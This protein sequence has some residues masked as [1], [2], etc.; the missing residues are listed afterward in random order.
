MKDT[1]HLYSDEKIIKEVRR[2]KLVFY[3]RTSS[4]FV[5]GIIPLIFISPLDI[6]LDSISD[7]KGGAVFGASFFLWIVVLSIIFFFRWT[8]YYLDVW[9]ITNKR[10]FDIEQR[11]MFNRSISVFL[12]SRI[13]DVT[14]ETEGLIATL[15]KFGTVHVHTA[16]EHHAGSPADSGE[17]VIEDA[18]NPI[19]I[20]NIIMD[21]HM[22]SLGH[23]T[24]HPQRQ[25]G[26]KGGV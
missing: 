8:D 12:L 10:I 18:D 11:G 4:L 15:F 7:G 14:V 19:M 6:L 23:N 16:G 26:T 22:H 17:L 9:V 2:H 1:L 24:T 20:K 25:S 21:A 3:F 13:Q 5:L